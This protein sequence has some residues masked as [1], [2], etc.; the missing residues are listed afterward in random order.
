MS[1]SLY[2]LLPL[3]IVLAILQATLL[4]RLP[5][6]GVILQPALLV[7]LAWTLLRGPFDGLVIAFIFG[8]ALDLFS[9]GPTGGMA[10]ALMVAA[11]PLTYL[12][13][14]L[15]ENPYV[16]PIL[17]M[18]LGMAVF[19][20]AYTL[21][22][23]AAQMGFRSNV[24]LTLPQTILLHALFGVPIYWSLRSLSRMLYPRQIEM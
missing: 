15:P 22:V 10:L 20:A 9:V 14:T 17:L 2:V 16:M 11:L 24:L 19:L 23:A 4:A 5:I 3:A 18:A 12:N 21:I 13:Q 8:L 7:A 6:F 1:R